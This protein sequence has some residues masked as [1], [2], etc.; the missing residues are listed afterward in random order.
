M[1]TSTNSG[2]ATGVHTICKDNTTII[3]KHNPTKNITKCQCNYKGFCNKFNELKLVIQ[4][5]N[6]FNICIQESH[7]KPPNSP[8]LLKSNYSSGEIQ[9][10]Q[11]YE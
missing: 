9:W 7:M 6:S 10:T 5:H 11:H 8:K 4:V 2:Y 1:S 3:N